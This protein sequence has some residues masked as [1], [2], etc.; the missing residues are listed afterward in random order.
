MSQDES[1]AT[2][3]PGSDPGDAGD[4]AGVGGGETPNHP[5]GDG[6]G[7]GSDVDPGAAFD[8]AAAQVIDDVYEL[9]LTALLRQLVRGG[10]TRARRGCWAWT[11]GRW[12]PACSRGCRGGC[13][14]RPPSASGPPAP[15]H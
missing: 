5:V 13:G 2:G 9:R 11:P 10:G 4:D 7:A 3:G 14:T 1:R 8:E 12:R 15:C 6:T